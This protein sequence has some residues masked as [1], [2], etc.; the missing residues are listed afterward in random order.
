RQ[1]L[2][3]L[4]MLLGLALVFAVALGAQRIIDGAKNAFGFIPGEPEVPIAIVQAIVQA[5][6]LFVTFALLYW[7]VPHGRRDFGGV[8]VGAGGATLLFLISR[9]LVLIWASRFS[10]YDEIYGP[11]ALLALLL[12]WAWIVALILLYGA[13]LATHTRIMRGQ[14]ATAEEANARRTGPR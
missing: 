3:Q 8:L 1:I 4:T 14:G 2:V 5:L 6:F 12:I 9:P 11:L 10:R 7:F 13:E